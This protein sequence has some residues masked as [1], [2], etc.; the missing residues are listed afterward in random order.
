[1][2]IAP[3]PLQKIKCPE[4]LYEEVLEV[5]ERILPRL[6]TSAE[7]IALE[8]WKVEQGSTGEKLLI[9]QEVDEV[10]LRQD[11]QQILNKGI[12]SLAVVLLHS[13]M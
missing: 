2:I 6:D 8:K 9:M 11:L 13:Y 5:R 10:K 3:F 1:M 4:V 7:E 12:T